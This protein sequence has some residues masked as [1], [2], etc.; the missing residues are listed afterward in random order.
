[1]FVRAYPPASP[2]PGAALWLPFRDESLV[3]AD[4]GRLLGD[5][6]PG[7]PVDAPM[8]LGTLDGL[9]CIAFRLPPDS[10][11]PDGTRAANLRALYGQTT[12]EEYALAGYALQMLEWQ[13]TSVYCSVCATA[14]VEHANDWARTCPACGYSRYPPVSPAV[15][16]L[17]H[18]GDRILL[19]HKPGWGKRFSI[20]AGFVEPGESLEDCARREIMEEA[21]ITVEDVAYAG[22]QPWPF[23]HQI[24][25]G[26]TMR[27][28][29]GDPRPDPSELDD[30]Q[31][32]RYDALPELPPPL[33]LSRQ[34]INQ[35]VADRRALHE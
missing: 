35:W 12:D 14:T 32:F 25:L 7:L 20:F 4:G 30:V 3:V 23:P 9:P 19:S 28:G 5:D 13:R 6:T 26:F 34:L 8:Y 17:V 27:Y 1:M 21:S 24:M 2:A 22:S 10:A 31:W 29:S 11:L 15:L 18:D 33:S 16:I